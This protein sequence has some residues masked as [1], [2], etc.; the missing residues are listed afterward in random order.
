MADRSAGKTLR[1]ILKPV[2]IAVP[3]AVV[4]YLA[5]YLSVF[6]IACGVIDFARNRRRDWA[7]VKRYF[8][9]NGLLTWLL[10]PLNLFADLICQPNRYIYRLDDLP[11]DCQRE[12]EGLIAVLRKNDVVEA[13][14]QKMADK[15]R[16]MIFFKW[17]GQNI[18]TS[19]HLPE[20]D[21]DFK[22]IRTIGV[23]AFNRRE[24]T[25]THFGPI[26][27]TLRVLYNLDPSASDDAFIEV[28]GRR[29]LWRDDPLFIFD[30]T[31]MH[32]SVND[33]DDIRYCM[34]VDILR[35]SHIEPVQ[36]ALLALVRLFM[37]N[38]R[39]VFY[40]NWDPIT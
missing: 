7:S 9:G 13:L 39:G 40:K 30:D 11:E 10:S 1:R 33:T 29:H 34:F 6:F 32:R 3:V 27:F 8:F 22:Y 5:P 26:R 37:V 4:V 20:F 19:I 21:K 12:V 38:V 24:S 18:D 28:L 17:Y 15:K 16:G 35:P 36:R 31:L 2:K 25:S 23:S 14:K